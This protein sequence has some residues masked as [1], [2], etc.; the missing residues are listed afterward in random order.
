VGV[1]MLV[2]VVN[3]TLRP[4]DKIKL[5]ATDSV[6]LVEDIGVF[7]PRPSRCRSC[8]PVRW[9]SSSPASRN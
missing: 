6:Q 8:R 2:R 9:A 3:G 4:K 5:M 1:V 7:S